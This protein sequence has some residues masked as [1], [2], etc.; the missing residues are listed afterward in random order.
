MLR[1]HALA[2]PSLPAHVA[3][4]TNAGAWNEPG[5]GTLV[6]AAPLRRHAGALLGRW[7]AR[8][9]R[10]ATAGHAVA[11]AATAAARSTA[12]AKTVAAASAAAQGVGRVE[13]AR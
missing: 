12:T 9:W 5:S 8:T 13:A 4:G 7:R 3:T 6:I 10:H 1:G 2:A 11:C